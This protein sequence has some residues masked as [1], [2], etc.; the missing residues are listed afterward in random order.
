MPGNSLQKK[1]KVFC[2][3]IGYTA[4]HLK[5]H[6]SFLEGTSRLGDRDTI[7]FEDV[8]KVQKT[9]ENVTHILISIPPTEEG[10]VTLKRY[11]RLLEDL[12][13][14]QWAGYLSSTSVY[15]DHQGRVVD[16]TSP[17]LPTNKRSLER[18]K[19]E[20]AWLAS[21]LPV[22][23]FRLSGIYGE[24][25]SI[26][27]RLNSVP[28]SPRIHKPG[29]KFSRCHVEDICQVL[30]ASMDK[31][32]AGEIF[33]V[34]DDLPA[35]PRDVIEYACDLLGYP[36]PPL[37]SFKEADL[38]QRAKEFY[39][40]HKSVSNEKIKSFLG[41]RLKYPTYKEGLKG[42]AQNLSELPFKP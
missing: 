35:E 8:T 31:P 6:F 7:C 17:C 15:G 39:D 40:D 24:G 16:E 18:L 21:R 32:T 41:I 37:V 19:A 38:S 13:S 22:H 33:N 11:G 9:L 34:A 30:M 20:E 23:I 10:D 3:G 2:F 27:S 5:R 12:D 42:I 29:H 1:H 28:L 36:Y 25:R 4:K 14:L 26:V